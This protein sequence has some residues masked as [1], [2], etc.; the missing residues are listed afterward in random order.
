M[1]HP[2][3]VPHQVVQ[4]AMP[5]SL[6]R[7]RKGGTERAGRGACTGGNR[8]STITIDAFIHQVE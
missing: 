4:P 3:Q 6:G 8:L 5:R 2:K 1:M 7:K